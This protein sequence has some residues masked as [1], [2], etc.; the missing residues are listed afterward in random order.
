[1]M[2][3]NVLPCRTFVELNVQ[4]VIFTCTI[5]QK[6]SVIVQFLQNCVVEE[7][8]VFILIAELLFSYPAAV[9]IAGG[10]AA[11]LTDTQ[12][13]WLLSVRVLD[14][15]RVTPAA[16]RNICLHGLIRRTGSHITQRYSNQRVTRI[17]KYLRR[18]SNR[19]A[20]CA[21]WENWQNLQY[22]DISYAYN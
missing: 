13:L 16:A 6:V 10:R 7:K 19:C 1:M 18:H 5:Q 2:G 12:H 11:N 4:N 15:L 17:V 8:K 9:T 22:R 14:L 20:T 3:G 21:T